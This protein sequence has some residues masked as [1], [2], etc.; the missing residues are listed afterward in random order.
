[1]ELEK[2]FSADAKTIVDTLFDNKVFRPDLT[3]DDM[4]AVEQLIE[5][6]MSSRMSSLIKIK[7]IMERVEKR[8][9]DNT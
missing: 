7:G 5:Y 6:M 2:H 9:N 4:T 3:R 1:M 8:A